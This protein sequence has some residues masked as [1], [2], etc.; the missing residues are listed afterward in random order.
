MIHSS[1]EI[2]VSPIVSGE[3]QGF[4]TEAEARARWHLMPDKYEFTFKYITDIDTNEVI[5]VVFERCDPAR[6][7]NHYAFGEVK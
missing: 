3:Q 4:R 2:P 6:Y 5:A 1:T 7:K